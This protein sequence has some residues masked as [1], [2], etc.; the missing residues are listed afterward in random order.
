MPGQPLQFPVEHFRFFET[1]I[2]LHIVDADLQVVEAFS[3][4]QPLDAFWSKQV[5]VG[6]QRSDA[7]AVANTADNLV[8]VWMKQGLSTADGDDGCPVQRGGRLVST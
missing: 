2:R 1:L 5:S 3:A 4:I 8:Q 6:D 7:A